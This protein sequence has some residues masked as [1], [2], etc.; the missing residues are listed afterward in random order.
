MDG[1]PEFQLSHIGMGEVKNDFV[2]KY[3][4]DYG[5]KEFVES[6]Y[7]TN[8]EGTVGSVNTNITA[9]NLDVTT[10]TPSA[11]A[12]GL[13][14]LKTLCADSYTEIGSTNTLEFEAWAIR[15]EATATKLLQFY[16]ERLTK[17]RAIIDFPADESMLEHEVGDIINVRHDRLYDR[18]GTGTTVNKKWEIIRT[19]H[20]LDRHFF[21]ITCI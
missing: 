11:D 21:T 10:L 3:K 6:L 5:R 19:V 12:T 18:Y 17:L 2:L 20:N 9:S 15:D 8:G 16:I 13:T 7:M 1:H 14:A 4:Y